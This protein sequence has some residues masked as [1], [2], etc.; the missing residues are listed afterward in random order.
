MISKQLQSPLSHGNKHGPFSV[1]SK[2]EKKPP[3]TNKNGAKKIWVTKKF[4]ISFVG[5]VNKKMQ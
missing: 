3:N 1:K 2:H 4:V 5:M